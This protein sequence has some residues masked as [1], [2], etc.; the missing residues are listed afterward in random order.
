MTVAPDIV[1]SGVLSGVGPGSP[2]ELLACAAALSKAFFVMFPSMLAWARC[3]H[4]FELGI[5][6]GSRPAAVP[7]ARLPGEGATAR[8]AIVDGAGGA[9]GGRI[10]NVNRGATLVLTIFDEDGGA[11]IN[12]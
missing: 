10:P 8:A 4:T 9:D 12:S 1:S 6:L 7:G 5:G 2:L 11:S 3:G